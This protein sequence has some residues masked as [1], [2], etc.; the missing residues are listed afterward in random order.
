MQLEYQLLA[1]QL[2][3]QQARLKLAIKAMLVPVVVA[4]PM[5]A[6]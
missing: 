1:L 6:A 4:R 5:L 2:S 3:M